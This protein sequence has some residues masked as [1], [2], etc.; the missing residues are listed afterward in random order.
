MHIQQRFQILFVC[1]DK[2][3]GV[4]SLF[5]SPTYFKAVLEKNENVY[6][7]DIVYAIANFYLGKLPWIIDCEDARSFYR[8]YE[9]GAPITSSSTSLF[10]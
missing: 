8:G 6:D 10:I 5:I 9:R 4:S 2:F 1:F 3:I 7:A